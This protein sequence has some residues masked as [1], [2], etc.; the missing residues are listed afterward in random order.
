MH[1]IQPIFVPCSC[2]QQF[3]HLLFVSSL[4]SVTT[5]PVRTRRSKQKMSLHRAASN[6]ALRTYRCC[7]PRLSTGKQ[8]YA[9]GRRLL[10]SSEIEAAR[11]SIIKAEE[12]ILVPRHGEGD[13]VITLNVGGKEFITLRS[14]IQ[15][16]QVL[17]NRVLQAEANQEFTK[18]AVFIDRDPTYFHLILQH[19]RNRADMMHYP[20]SFQSSSKYAIFSR[21]MPDKA[22]TI[23]RKRDVLIQLPEKKE[24]VRDLYVEAR[25]FQIAELEALLCSL[26]WY[27]R[28]AQWFGSGASNPFYAA[29]QA[30]TTARRALV[31]SSG[32]GIVLGAQNEE[33]VKNI[34]GLLSDFVTLFT[35]GKPND[36][37][38]GKTGEEPAAKAPEKSFFSFG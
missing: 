10:S 7:A 34:K 22:K 16:N 32:F 21:A 13:G 20:R 12:K 18:G 11:E 35:G 14:T 29:S 27:T 1:N 36:D 2:S 8:R 37:S 26:D 9:A 23:F 28:A 25:Y 17:Y 19:L 33:L 4:A 15:D 24:A 5:V 31:A 6:L 38:S 3:H 30:I